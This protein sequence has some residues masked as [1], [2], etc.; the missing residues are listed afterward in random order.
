MRLGGGLELLAQLDGAL[1]V[2][3]GGDGELGHRRLGLRHPPRDDLLGA[4]EL[5]DADVALGG[6]RLGDARG[7]RGRRRGG[8]ERPAARRPG[9]R[10]A[11]PA[12]PGAACGAAR[13][14]P[15]GGAGRG[16][17]DVGLHDPPARARCPAGAERSMPCSR[18][19][20]RATGD[21]FARPP[22]PSDEGVAG[23][24]RRGL[25]AGAAAGGSAVAAAVGRGRRLARRAVARR[26]GLLGR[27]GLRAVAG[28]RLAAGADARDDLA[29]GQRLALLGDDR[30]R[31]RRC[32]P[33]RSSWPCRSRSPRARR[34]A[35]PRRP[36]P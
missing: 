20:R 29:D 30:Q 36:R 24:R 16:G 3:V 12:R 28:R 32:R 15:R 11:R 6:A 9:P 18:A 17:L 4:R 27:L 34:R 33:R 22:L 31:A 23:R 35:R 14:A 25:R 26:L 19:M 2:D 7:R 8:A 5:L 1:H 21:A 10:R 13:P